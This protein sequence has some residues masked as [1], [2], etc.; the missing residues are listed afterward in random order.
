M[1]RFI[2]EQKLSSVDVASKVLV[3]SYLE[4]SNTQENKLSQIMLF[5]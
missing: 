3:F 5:P 2:Q 4:K 1:K